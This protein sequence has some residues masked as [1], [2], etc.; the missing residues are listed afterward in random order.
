MLNSFKRGVESVL[1]RPMTDGDWALIGIVSVVLL[2]V[3]V[4]VSVAV[5][6]HLFGD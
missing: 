6:R 3:T 2:I 5:Y 1:N 4:M